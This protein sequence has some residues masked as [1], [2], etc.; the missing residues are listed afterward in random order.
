M[1]LILG[2]NWE[3]WICMVIV[4]IGLI[5]NAFS[6]YFLIFLNKEYYSILDQKEND[7]M[8][9]SMGSGFCNSVLFILFIHNVI[10]CLASG[11]SIK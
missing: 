3:K 6:G 7:A 11:M 2:N 1:F 10:I 5:L 4:F 9:K 8:K